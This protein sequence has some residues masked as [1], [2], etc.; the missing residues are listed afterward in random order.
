M[1]RATLSLSA[2]LP[3]RL[4]DIAEPCGGCTFLAKCRR[5]K[6]ACED[7]YRYAKGEQM[8]GEHEHRIPGEYWYSMLWNTV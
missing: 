6:I 4:I 5:G 1:P 2:P 8:T 3:A 7:F